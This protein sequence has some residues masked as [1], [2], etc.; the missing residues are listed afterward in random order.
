MSIVIGKKY[1]LKK[2]IGSGSFGEIF[3]AE[4]TETS[5]DV[6]VKLESIYKRPSQ[7]SNEKVVY[8]ILSGSTG[9]P[10]IHYSGTEG[11]YN[12][13]VM[14]LL[15]PSLSELFLRCN[16][17]FSLKTTLM[18]AQQLL[19][20]IEYIHMKGFLH[21][22]IKP[23]NF[24]IGL[25]NKAGNIFMFDY[26]ISSR[27]IDWKTKQHIEFRDGRSLTGTA[28]YASINVHGGIEPSRRDDLESIAYVLIYF[29][30]GSLPWENVK[31]NN[32]S[33]KYEAILNMKKSI[34]TCDLCSG[35]PKE[36]QL[37]LDHVR[38]LE[39][40]DKPDYAFY[41]DIFRDLFIR[42][43]YIFDYYYDWWDN[44]R[45]LVSLYPSQTKIDSKRNIQTSMS[46]LRQTGATILAGDKSNRTTKR[47]I[48]NRSKDVHKFTYK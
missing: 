21:R 38:R 3:I 12:V 16:K 22:D 33:E 2:K 37:F 25:N 27:Y 43:G 4:N 14:D 32:K 9:V 24:S 6:A 44:E 26:G 30:K 17:K 10:S 34:H 41:R 7:L 47:C 15:G 35:I 28:R 19:A 40:R 46:T 18:L 31:L 20:R 36:F 42:E 23:E 29:L 11:D 5:E 45:S 8:N 39:F 48:K 1:K 13:I